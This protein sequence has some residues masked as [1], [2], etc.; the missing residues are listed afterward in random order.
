MVKDTGTGDMVPQIE[1]IEYFGDAGD[2]GFLNFDVNV[3]IDQAALEDIQRE[4]KQLARLSDTPRIAPVL[5]VD[6][7]VKMMLFGKQTPDPAPT[8]TRGGG[9]SPTPTGTGTG[10]TATDAAPQFVVKINQSAHPSLYGDNQASFSVSLDG[11]GVTV[12]SA[13][14]KGEMSPIGVVYSLDY[15][16]LRPAYS[17]KLNVDWNRVQKHLDQE[18]SAQ[19]FFASVD[20]DK[21]VD[22]LIE[23]RAITLEADTFVPEGDDSK[24]IISRRDQAINEVRDMIINAFFQPSLDPIKQEKDGWDKASQLADRTSAML[25][26]GGLAGLASFS[27]KNVDYTRID[28]KV[29]NVNI[30]ERTTVKRSMYPNGHLSGLFRPVIQQGLNLDR[31]ILHVNTNDPWFAHRKVKVIS[32]ANF[33]FESIQSINVELQY[34]TTPQNVILDSSTAQKDVIWDSIVVNNAMQREVTV[35]YTV[36]FKDVVGTQW[37]TKLTSSEAILTT[38]SIE[39]KPSADLYRITP[40]ILTALNFPWDTYPFVEVHTAYSDPANHIQLSQIFLFEKT[41]AEQSWNIFMLDPQKSHFQYRLTYR[42]A[43]NKDI[44]MSLVDSNESH[45]FIRDPYPQKRTLTVV[46]DLDWNVVSRAFVDLAYVDAPNNVSEEQSF[47]FDATH[48]DMQTFSVSLVNPNQRLVSYEVSVLFK[49]SHLAKVPTSFTLERRIFI[50]SDMKGHKIILVHPAV[51]DFATQKIREMKVD[52]RY[53][54]TSAGLNFADSF[55]FKSSTDQAHFEFD[56]V[57]ETKA[58]YLYEVTYLYTNGL[59]RSVDWVSVASD[60]LVIPSV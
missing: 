16:A 32:R 40:V 4:L 44:E 19:T 18:F 55:D 14:L 23:Q 34:G 26:T 47:A 56:Y 10:T 48:T 50:R 22:Q 5:L 2:G 13:A 25:A 49:D 6:G 46:P 24:D 20:I 8:P 29:L 38:E 45:I 53:Q 52:I 59:S 28:Q 31:F 42:A 57:D 58:Q 1:V 35:K 39:I 3:G 51:V 12:L 17:I 41:H 7:T 43:D 27:Y 54:D 21:A 9:T 15:L 33:D 36:T 37:P 11:E 30:S 60:E